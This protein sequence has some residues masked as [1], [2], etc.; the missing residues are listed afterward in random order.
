M[1]AAKRRKATTKRATARKSAAPARRKATRAPAR[2]TRAS[3][4]KRP[5]AKAK[6]ATRAAAKRA[7]ASKARKTAAKKTAAKTKARSTRA[8]AKLRTTKA[9][10]KAR[11]TKVKARAAKAKATRA[12]ATRARTAKAAKTRATR[13]RVAKPRTARTR[14][15]AGRARTAKAAKKRVVRAKATKPRLARVKAAKPRLVRRKVAA[16][17]ERALA[18]QAAEPTKLRKKKKLRSDEEP[19][20][21]EKLKLRDG[22]KQSAPVEAER[23]RRTSDKPQRASDRPQRASDRPQRASDRPQRASDRPISEKKGLAKGKGAASIERRPGRVP[24]REPPRIVTLPLPMLPP[25]RRATI[26][27]RSAL[28]EQRLNAQTEEFR[29][30]YIESLDMS[31]IYHDSALEGVVYTF[32]ELRAALSGPAPLVADSSLQ[33]TYDDIRRHKEAIAYVREQGENKRAPVTVDCVKKLYLILHPEEG[34]IKTVKYRKDIPQHR[35]YFHEYAPPDKIAYKVRQIID[36][37]N[38]PETR[39]TRNGIRIAAR[40]HYD[41]LRVYPFPNDSGKVARLFMNM[42]L[43]RTGLPPSII[44]STERQRYYEAL[45]GSATT[46]LQMV[47][48]SVENALASV[49]KLLDEHETRKRAF[50]S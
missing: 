8:A 39:K 26:E 5:A 23:P 29:R 17:S 1:K 50:V 35:L 25:P 37:L 44:H 21:K 4:R 24:L 2:T 15:V 9:R 20:L 6:K 27:E 46:V 28:I 31:W 12:K 40:A 11:A 18:A 38:D 19:R 16:R 41:L 22:G 7:G 30:R 32:D 45:K 42:L 13:A 10:A 3:A 43:L 33:P 14:A 48:E 49:E 34:D 47:Q 36:W